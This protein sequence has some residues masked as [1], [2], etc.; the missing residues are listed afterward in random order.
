MGGK[1]TFED[2]D[3]SRAKRRR[4]RTVISDF[5]K[6]RTALTVGE[7]YR[8]LRDAPS[9][10]DRLGFKA[11]EQLQLNNLGYGR[12]DDAWVYEFQAE[13]GALKTYWLGDTDPIE[14]LTSTF[15]R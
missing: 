13:N 15:S 5:E 3:G 14:Q 12:Y 6:R 8:V 10:P 1:L 11:G 2:L 9:F 4:T 7:H